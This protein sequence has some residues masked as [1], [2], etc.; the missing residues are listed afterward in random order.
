MENKI[1]IKSFKDL[2]VYQTSYQTMLI[3]F[4][5]ILSVL[6]AQEKFDL[7]NQLSRSIKAAPR[8]IAEGF[9]KRNQ[10]LGFQKYL[11]D[12]MAENNETIV[13]LEQCRDLY[14]IKPELVNKLIDKYDKVSRQLYKLL[15]SWDNIKN[16]KRFTPNET[17]IDTEKRFTN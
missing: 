14:N 6:P 5:E 2:D 15:V 4:R 17:P 12:A 3:V 1:R 9:A 10:K 16:V 11:Y 13:G 7:C 8:L